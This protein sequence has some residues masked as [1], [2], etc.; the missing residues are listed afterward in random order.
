MEAIILAGGL[1]TRLK[2]V[3]S[4]KPKALSIVAGK[5]FLSYIIDFLRE[6]GIGHFIFSIGYL[7]EQIID[8]LKNEYPQIDYSICLEQKPLG[9]GGGIKK[10]LSHAIKE[11]VLIVNADTFFEINVQ[12]M[13]NYHL[14]SRASCTIALKK[15]HDFDRYGTV[16][17]DDT[18]R[19]VSFKEKSYRQE[20]LINGGY[21]FLKTGLLEDDMLPETFSFEQDFLEHSL[22]RL[23]VKG[24]IS[25]GYFIDIGI[26]ADYE[27][28][29]VE[30][31]SFNRL[32]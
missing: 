25:D 18:N 14:A 7:S 16:E 11:N 26:P 29:Q 20:G 15:M 27:K 2:Q 13:Y 1:G 9:T 24:F 4:D 10:A 31:K 23:V 6:Q 28:A 12:A 30:F 3:V 8:F 19:V 22:S 32:R 17:L 21:L 5:P